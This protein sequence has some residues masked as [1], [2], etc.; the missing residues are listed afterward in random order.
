[1]KSSDAFFSYNQSIHPARRD[2]MN[3]AGIRYL[4]GADAPQSLHGFLILWTG[5]SIELTKNVEQWIRRAGEKCLQ[6]DKEEIGKHLL[7]HAKHEADH[8]QMLVKDLDVL[9]KM[10]NQIYHGNMS[11]DEIRKMPAP[12]SAQAYGQLHEDVIA[13]E[14]PY[15]QVAIEF[16]IERLS[17]MFGPKMQENVL[18]TLGLEITQG[19]TFLNEHILLD[20]GHTA[21][22]SALMEKC[23]ADGC[24]LPALV[25]AGTKAL[26][27]YGE[28]LNDCLTETTKVFGPM[29]HSIGF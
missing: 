2:F 14:H 21:F 23:L 10:W 22:N 20:Q 3:Q 28:F 16:E 9:V 26:Q 25:D 24:S 27:I 18:Y 1:M 8:D 6:I 13:S 7:Q 4:I 11:A 29:T 12:A 19:L 17:V 15:G 5:F